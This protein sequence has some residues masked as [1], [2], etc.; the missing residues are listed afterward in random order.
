MH[1]IGS[2]FNK[3]K[4]KKS[5]GRVPL[6]DQHLT[7]ATTDTKIRLTYL[8]HAMLDALGSP[9]QTEKRDVNRIVDEMRPHPTAKRPAGVWT[10]DTSMM[11]CVSSALV[12]A[13][14]PE[15]NRVEQMMALRDWRDSG[16]LSFTG[17]CFDLKRQVGT[18]IDQFAQFPEVP[19]YG[20]H[21]VRSTYSGTTDD[22]SGNASL[23]RVLPLAISF[24]REPD[25][26][27]IYGKLSSE[28]THPSL[29]C[30]EASSLLAYFIAFILDYNTPN[31]HLQRDP[32]YK[33]S[34]LTF[35]QECARF[36]FE[37]NYLL[38]MLTVPFGTMN[39]PEALDELEEWYFKYVPLL[40][41]ITTTQVGSTGP[42]PFIIPTEEQLPSTEHALDT[43]LAAL[44]CFFATKTFEEGALM[45]VNLCGEAS[46]VGSVYAG[47]AGVWYAGE[48]GK[49]E[50]VF[51]TKRVRE[52]RKALL[53][54]DVVDA[55]ARKMAQLAWKRRND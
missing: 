48:E 51:W 22:V 45:A 31:P 18:A 36:P 26:A 53:K 12:V 1:S 30:K 16:Y 49:A 14:D 34:K 23:P 11:L 54:A 55:E 42:F 2:L 6:R 40:R 20:L 27:R 41:L 46:T 38:Q 7:H 24:W 35:I 13:E 17:T 21:I 52:W 3:T 47:L 4:A 29:V 25:Q 44:F 9:L 39:R 15:E 5:D 50:K 43:T 37:N 10:D 19:Q 8:A 28:V 32:E 33:I